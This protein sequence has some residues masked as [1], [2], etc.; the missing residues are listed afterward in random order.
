MP[1]HFAGR[2]RTADIGL[3]RFPRHAK[4]PV[5]DLPDHPARVAPIAAASTKFCSREPE[6]V[7]ASFSDCT[8]RIRSMSLCR[9]WIASEVPMKTVSYGWLWISPAF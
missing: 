9:K 7:I 4:N 8:P 6:P 3:G 1:L 2:G 5:V